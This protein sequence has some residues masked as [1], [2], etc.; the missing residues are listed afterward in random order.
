MNASPGG[1]DSNSMICLDNY[2]ADWQNVV[3]ELKKPNL[4]EWIPYQ[5]TADLNVFYVFH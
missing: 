5:F 4:Q 2:L 3:T 1:G